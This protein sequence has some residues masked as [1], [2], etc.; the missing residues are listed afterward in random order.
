MTGF[1]FSGNPVFS[2]L[3]SGRISE[4]SCFATPEQ[5]IG[6]EYRQRKRRGKQGIKKPR[7]GVTS[8][9]RARGINSER[10]AQTQ[11]ARC[12]NAASRNEGVSVLIQGRLDIL[13]SASD[14]IIDPP[15][16]RA[17]IVG[18]LSVPFL[19]H[20]WRRSHLFGRRQ[21]AASNTGRELQL[22]DIADFVT[23]G[24]NPVE[25]LLGVGGRHTET[26][27]R[28]NQGSSGVTNNHDGD[29]APKHLVGECGHLG[30]VEKKNR[31]D[32]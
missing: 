19:L 13:D 25:V 8:T 1:F 7:H 14:H 17:E 11:Y 20:L 23:G 6:T 24:Q 16:G 31:N 28:R 18:A 15:P 30:R 4:T 21:S 27:T 32:W 5:G 2:H 26:G 3:L 10:K 9:N 12:S 22:Q 29:L